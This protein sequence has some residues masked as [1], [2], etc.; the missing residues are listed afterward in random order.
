MIRK[1]V[2]PKGNVVGTIGVSGRLVS[3]VWSTGEMMVFRGNAV[4]IFR[5]G[6]N[7]LHIPIVNGKIETVCKLVPVTECPEVK[8][9]SADDISIGNIH[10][11]A[12][13]S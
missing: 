12:T 10:W 1:I 5:Q 9:C 3:I 4:L 13:K 11:F 6:R 7:E 2:T 8:S